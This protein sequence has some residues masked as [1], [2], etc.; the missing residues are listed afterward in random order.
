VTKMGSKSKEENV[1]GLFFNES[2]K[3]WH[4]TEI[5]RQAK[6]SRQ[7]ANKWLK[8]LLKEKVIVKVKS[9]GKMPF[10]KAHFDHPNYQY[11]KRLFALQ[12]LYDSG[13][14]T[15]LKQLPKAR[16]IIIF[17]SYARADWHT[18][19]DIDLFIYGD[20]EGLDIPTYWGK[21]HRPIQPWVFPSSE[22]MK[23]VQSGLLKNVINGY[24]VKGNL[25]EIIELVT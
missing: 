18:T 25:N 23:E 22:E 4:F 6:I 19:S 1:L 8:K 10:F 24:L 11:K 2:S 7:Q 20:D 5:L 13:F 15:H 3:H 17:G 21:L 14:L 9:K 16:T 12:E